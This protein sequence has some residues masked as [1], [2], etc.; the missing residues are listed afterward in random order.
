LTSRFQNCG[1][2]CIA[3]KRFIV[4]QKVAEDFLALFKDAVANLTP[5]DPLDENTKVGPM[6]R[7]NLLDELHEQ[8]ADSLTEGAI[9]VV[10]CERMD[11]IGYYYAPSILDG[12]KPDMR[13]YRE[14]VFGPAATIIRVRDENEALRIANDSLFGLGGSVWTRD[15]AR[16]K[17]FASRMACGLAFVN[18]QVQSDPR[19]PFGGIKNSG[20]GREL[21]YHGIREF[22]NIKTLWID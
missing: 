6:A 14:E 22:T 18:A 5:G 2:S 16:G 17:R 19:V 1:Q 7:S 11:S 12:V 3:A 4:E 20:Y 9:A 13:V 15:V 10:G 21:S 8:I